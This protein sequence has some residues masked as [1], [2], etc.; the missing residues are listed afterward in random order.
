MKL[1]IK[2][3]VLSTTTFGLMWG[4]AQNVQATNLIGG[5]T[6]STTISGQATWNLDDTVNGKGLPGNIPSLI[7]DHAP[8]MNGDSWRS[9]V[10]P[11]LGST[12]TI[13]FNL[14]GSYNLGGFTFWNI[15]GG[16]QE[17]TRQGISGVTIEYSSNGGTTWT[18][19]TG[20]PNSFTQGTSGM[21]ATDQTPQSFSF[22]PVAATQ[23]RFIN[24]SNFGGFTTPSTNN[25]IG[26][27][28]IQFAGTKIPEPSSLLA[29]LAFGLAGVSLGKR[30]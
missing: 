19:L 22:A 12:G 20:A 4:V 24:L 2:T 27:S 8:S 15:G 9:V 23:V 30:I 28:E 16:S 10:N 26:F 25:R 3:L 5:V 17:L 29:L 1:T 6:A 7:G 13:T 11:T 14:N 21:P 18:S